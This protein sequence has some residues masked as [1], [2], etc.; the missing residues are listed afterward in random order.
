MVAAAVATA[1][2]FSDRVSDLLDR[3]DYRLIETGDEREQIFR[4]RYEAYLREGAIAPNFTKKLSDPFDDA[5]NSWTFG[6][7]VD[8]R[9]VASF[10]ISVSSPEQPMTPAVDAFPDLLGPEI[11]RGKVIIDSNRFVADAAAARAFPGLPHLAVRLGYLACIYFDADIATAT[12]RRE[13]QAFYKRVFTGFKAVC[14]PRPYPSL[15]KPLSLMMLDF[16]VERQKILARNPFF[17][18]TFFERRMMF[19]RPDLPRRT[20]AML[21]TK[22]PSANIN[23]APEPAASAGRR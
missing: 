19:E 14:E 11:E 3:L 13:H 12:V 20:A 1:R 16:R 4:L 6:L 9:I 21:Q 2:G 23:D 10:R 17:R 22:L 15:T 7:H 18:S 8:G 5:E